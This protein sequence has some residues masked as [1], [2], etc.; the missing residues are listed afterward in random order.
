MSEQLD[1]ERR[2]AKERPRS[3]HRPE[4]RAQLA[5]SSGEI[6]AFGVNRPD[7]MLPHVDRG[8]EADSG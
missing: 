3:C 2:K 4:N 1:E 7:A 5:Q 6:L 8:S